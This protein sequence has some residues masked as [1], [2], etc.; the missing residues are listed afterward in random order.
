MA[1][2]LLTVAL[3]L[4]LSAGTAAGLDVTSCNTSVPMGGNA[5]LQNDL[6]CQPGDSFAVELGDRARLSMNGHTIQNSGGFSLHSAVSCLGHCKILGPGEIVGPGSADGAFIGVE[7]EYYYGNLQ[8]RVKISDVD[9]R[10]TRVGIE[11]AAGYGI[12][13]TT[14]VSVTGCTQ[15][16]I[17]AGKLTARNVEVNGNGDGIVGL[18]LTARGLDVSGNRG[19]GVHVSE[20]V[21]ARFFTATDNGWYGVHTSALRLIDATVTGNGGDTSGLEGADP[22]TSD[23]DIAATRPPRLINTVCGK[24]VQFFPP[25]A[26]WD[27]CLND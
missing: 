4:G 10:G 9:I 2:T 22:P 21:T 8:H 23:I 11:D 6:V 20:K 12:V 16:G 19:Y 18:S 5:I 3:A 7:L 24:S 13:S 17:Q 1:R 25:F 26:D 15:T 27:V 14:N